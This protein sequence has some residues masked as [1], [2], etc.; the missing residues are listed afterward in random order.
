MVWNADVNVLKGKAQL[1]ENEPMTIV[2][3]SN[4]FNSLKASSENATA[5]LVQKDDMIELVL[6]G[7]RNVQAEWMIEFAKLEDPIVSDIK[8]NNTGLPARCYIPRVV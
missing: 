4:G 1:V 6:T 7:D 2:I 3:V 5:S 8:I